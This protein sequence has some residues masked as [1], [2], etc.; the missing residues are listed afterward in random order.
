MGCKMQCL[1]AN[2]PR[3]VRGSAERDEGFKPSSD[4]T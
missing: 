1:Q 2:V 4:L 3:R